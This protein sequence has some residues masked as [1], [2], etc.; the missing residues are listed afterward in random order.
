ML[1]DDQLA[2]RIGPR[3]RAEL[4]GLPTP[5]MLAA[6]RR[7]RARRARVTA[8]L[9]TLPVAAAAIAAAIVLPGAAAPTVQHAQDTAY[10]VSH[11]T[12][13]LTTV[14]A[15]TILSMQWT[16]TGPG[17]Q[18]RDIWQRDSDLR[19]ESFASGQLVSESVSTIRGTT[20]T[21]VRISYQHRTWSR[22]AFPI[23]KSSAP[24]AA[25]RALA[26][27]HIACD[28]A[29]ESF[30]ISDKASVM[31]AKLRAWESCGWLKADGTATAGG[32]TAIRLTTPT[33]DG[34]TT[35][36]YINP[37][38]YLPIRQTVTQQG[39]LLSTNDFQWLPPTP[40]NLAKLNLPTPP[41]GFTQE[42]WSACNG[43]PS[44]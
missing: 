31:A 10:V 39:T 17:S 9:T 26:Q 34:Y 29:N 41:R 44:C 23:G 6:L 12:Q 28:R 32:V 3:L 33:D 22:S 38:T 36:W 30:G 8:A 4:A 14:P 42:S 18:V 20:R 11:A 43:S 37:A 25:A 16:T 19:M 1:T 40:A 13:A 24:S 21:V 15:G 2:A 5:D 27:G 7:R 35:T